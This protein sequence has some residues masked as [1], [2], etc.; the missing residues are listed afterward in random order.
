MRRK[1][2]KEEMRF[3]AAPTLVGSASVCTYM[4][5]FANK[6]VRLG[7]GVDRSAELVCH[8]VSSHCWWAKRIWA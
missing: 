3:L 5:G 8:P 4:G 7:D 6:G 2:E 1:H